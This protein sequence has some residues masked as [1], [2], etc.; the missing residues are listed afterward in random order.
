MRCVLIE[1]MGVISHAEFERIV[2]GIVD[3]RELIVKHNPI[4]TSE[5]TLLWMLLSCLVSYLSLT[6][7][8]TPC[9]TGRPDTETYRHAIRFIIRNHSA[10]DFDTDPY[11][12][13]LAGQ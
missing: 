4:G 5:E 9:F 11:L 12:A 7:A 10:T 6:D 2:Q 1:H 8:E 13:K 3:D